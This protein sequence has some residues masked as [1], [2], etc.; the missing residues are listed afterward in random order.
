MLIPCYWSYTLQLLKIA[1]GDS[2]PAK[3]N[4]ASYLGLSKGSFLGYILNFE[5]MACVL[6]KSLW[7]RGCLLTKWLTWGMQVL[8]AKEI[9]HLFCWSWYFASLSFISLIK[10][11][12]KNCPM[13]HRILWVLW[14]VVEVYTDDPRG[15]TVDHFVK[16]WPDSRFQLQKNL[17]SH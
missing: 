4:L 5:N 11:F 12:P 7:G 14:K 2:D 8:H 13:T 3:S 15:N 6:T 10:G 17:G 1:F 9:S 16:I